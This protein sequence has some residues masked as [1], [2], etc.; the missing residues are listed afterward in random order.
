[1]SPGMATKTPLEERLLR[2]P[3][4]YVKQVRLMLQWIAFANEPLTGNTTK[5]SRYPL[6]LDQLAGTTMILSEISTM[7]S[8]H[9]V[10]VATIARLLEG[11]IT[12]EEILSARSR[13]DEE[14]ITS[15]EFVDGVREELLSK[16]LKTGPAR[17]FAIN[18]A[19]AKEVILLTCLFILTELD[20]SVLH[21]QFIDLDTRAKS[22]L[23]HFSAL[24]WMDFVGI[25]GLSP[26]V[27]TVIRDLF[28]GD[29]MTFRAWIR[30]IHQANSVYPNN[31]HASMISAISHHSDRE[32]GDHAPPI[33]WAA[34][35]NLT[36]IVDDLLEEGNSVN[37]AGGKGRVS[38]LYMAVHEKH[39]DMV[40][41]LLS[42]GGDVADQN[43]ELTGQFE[44]PWAVSPLYHVSHSRDYS[45]QWLDLLLRDKS[46]LGQPGWRLEVAMAYAARSGG[47]DTLKALINA[48]ADLNNGTGHEGSYR[49]PLQAACDNNREEVV[50]FLLERGADP[51]KSG[52]Y[53]W[54]GRI[55]SPLQVAACR[56]DH[57]IMKTLLLHGADPN[58]QGGDLGNPLI[59]AIW[60]ARSDG[61]V[62]V[63]GL[64]LQEGA[65][66]EEEWDMGL[67]LNDLNFEDSEDR[68]MS[69][70][71]RF[72]QVLA[73]W[74]KTDTYDEEDMSTGSEAAL[75]KRIDEKWERIHRGQRQELSTFRC[76]CMNEKGI[77]VDHGQILAFAS[78]FKICRDIRKAAVLIS[79]RLHEAGIAA[80]LDYRYQANAIQTAVAMARP[81]LVA[82]LGKSGAT[83]PAVIVSGPK[84]AIAD[85]ERVAQVL[86]QRESFDYRTRYA[87]GKL[88]YSTTSSLPKHSEKSVTSPRQSKLKDEIMVG[89]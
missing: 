63:A 83:I 14:R 52:G 78:R 72:G 15:V 73:R 40:A 23:A 80:D 17:H 9:H 56:G 25:E 12:T 7:E 2:I 22:P 54:L 74:I 47:L 4:H 81:D 62:D 64:L 65:R 61:V 19:R 18:E 11:I 77:L 6:T 60:Y 46:R 27:S 88:G 8:C 87:G 89:E 55:G 76:G 67:R 26:S 50:R 3:N 84:Q 51:N 28:L 42:A 70:K 5:R 75:R 32:T 44:Y 59:A 1:M 20:D 34:A 58:I 29:P 21:F 33:V 30:L 53:C 45:R 86:R 36:L 24:F 35:I 13:G 85:A 43:Q 38:A 82:L 16:S 49:C 69:L 66:L 79:S 71:A 39:F 41:R 10:D 48:G 57:S 31:K 68:K 37:A